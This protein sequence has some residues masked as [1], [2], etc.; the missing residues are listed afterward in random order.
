ME[1]NNMEKF[2]KNKA[3]GYYLIVAEAV[4]ALVFGLIYMATFQGAIGNNASGNVPESVGIYMLAGA[5]VAIVACVLPQYKVI[6]FIAV[7]LFGLSLYK[8]VFLIP[9]FI[10]GLAN[11]IEYN[12]GSAKMN[13]FYL[14]AQLVIL[15]LA[16][17]SIFLK[18]Y[19]SEEEED[20]EFRN[21][22]GGANIAKLGAGALV[23]VAALLVSALA[24]N[25]M[26]QSS[27]GTGGGNNSQSQSQQEEKKD[28]EEDKTEKFNP[29][30]DEIKALAAAAYPSNDPKDLVYAKEET[31]DFT[32][33][34]FT[35]LSAGAKTR[36]GH[37]LAYL[38]EG[39]YSE[40]YQG[41]YNEYYT[42][43]YLWDD[44]MMTGK[45]NSQTFKGY[46]YN[47]ADGDGTVDCLNMVSDS[48]KYA[49][50]VT[51]KSTGFY[52]AQA[53]VFMHPGWGEGRSII[54]SGYVYYDC[55]ALAID[56][57]ST[58]LDFKVGDSFSTSDWTLNRILANLSYGAVFNTPDGD[59]ST[60]TKWTI[61]SGLLVDGKFA[62]SGSFEIKASWGGFET[63]V[64]IN[65]AA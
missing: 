49:S 50:L 33:A 19:K 20:A 29:I 52:S 46:W 37:E 12:G 41:K 27:A 14:A 6:N 32:A 21:V 7:I 11:G 36:D 1:A 5:A 15:I 2:F 42:N 60:Q 61:P 30:T 25:G 13:I 18:T 57:T 40:G 63:S 62:Q 28:E 4:L 9:D 55:V 16:I 58:G 31:Y 39:A 44:G 47:D 10:A 65:V 17:V 45:S 48:T 24:V 59:S 35:A 38:F 34:E 51:S 26:K 64:T 8:E 22:S 3:F 56:T 53:Y 54:V 23:A 43:L